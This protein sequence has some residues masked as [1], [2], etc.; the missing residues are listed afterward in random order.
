MH[1]FISWY[2]TNMKTSE[3]FGKKHG[4]TKQVDDLDHQL[5]A[6]HHDHYEIAQMHKITVYVAFDKRYKNK[7]L[8]GYKIEYN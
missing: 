3:W 8:Q 5:I 1:D 7:V 6:K 2:Q 4:D